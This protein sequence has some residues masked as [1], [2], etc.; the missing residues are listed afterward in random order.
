MPEIPISRML[1][2]GIGALRPF[3]DT[4]ERGDFI[5]KRQKQISKRN[6]II[7]IQLFIRTAMLVAEMHARILR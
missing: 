2:R 1:S 7:I 3:W 6:I 4:W 5:G